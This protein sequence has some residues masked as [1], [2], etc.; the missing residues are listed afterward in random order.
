VWGSAGIRL[1]SGPDSQIY[2][3]NITGNYYGVLLYSSSPRVSILDNT[4][5]SNEFGVRV[6]NG[7][8]GYLNVSNNVVMNNRGYGIGL[9]GSTTGSH[10]ATIANNLIMNN[11][12][13]MYLGRNSNYN[14]VSRNNIIMNTHGLYVEFSTENMIYS[15]NFVDSARWQA[16]AHIGYFNSTDGVHVIQPSVNAWDNGYPSGGNYWSDYSGADAYKGF[17]QNETGSDGI[18]DT[19]VIVEERPYPLLPNVDRYPLTAPWTKILGPVGDVNGD[20]KVDMKDISY[21][22][23]RFMCLPSEG[24]WDPGADLNGD[25]RINMTD[26]G[27]AV[28][29][30]RARYDNARR[31]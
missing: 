5:A 23:R 21:V 22:A 18:G 3:N 31:N 26:T 11:G 13:G 20:G 2:S 24:L 12:D 10:N 19:P 15:N 30:R 9:M 6:L 14:T 16:F 4:I 8:S 27:I 17:Y 25:G 28:V 29:A 1:D 7:G